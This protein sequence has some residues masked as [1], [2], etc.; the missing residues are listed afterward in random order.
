[1]ESEV[2]SSEWFLVRKSVRFYKAMV[3]I[4]L[5]VLTGRYAGIVDYYSISAPSFVNA[6]STLVMFFGNIK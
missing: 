3:A 6:S 1:M 5:H 2:E 4:Q